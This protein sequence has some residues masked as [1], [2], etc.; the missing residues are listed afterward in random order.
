MQLVE[1]HGKREFV[2]R[3]FIQV[4]VIHLMALCVGPWLFTWNAFL[5]AFGSALAFGYSLGIFHHMLLTHRS[6]ECASFIEKLGSLLGTLTWRGPMAAPVRY[7][8]MHKIHHA[9][10]DKEYDPHSPHHGIWHSLLTW[11]WNMPHGFIDWENY[12]STHRN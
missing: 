7:V 10:A 8:A 9:Y 5:F 1:G 11:F 4:L 12:A 6:F 2:L 3:Y